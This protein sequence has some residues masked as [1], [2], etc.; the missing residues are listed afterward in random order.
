LTKLD[1]SSSGRHSKA[2]AVMAMVRPERWRP[3]FRLFLQ[4]RPTVMPEK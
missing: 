3:V 1:D 2:G 4:P